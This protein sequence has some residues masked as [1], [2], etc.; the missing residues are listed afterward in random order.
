[1]TQPPPTAPGW[2]PDPSGT[3]SRYWDGNNWGPAAPPGADAPTPPRKKQPVP[4]WVIVFAVIAVLMAIGEIGSH[5]DSGH[6]ASQSS[7]NTGSQ[8]IG[9]GP[10]SEAG[11]PPST[12]PALAMVGQEVHD[13]KFAFVVNSVDRSKTAGDPSNEIE[14]VTAQGEFLNVHMTVTNVGDRTQNFFA[15]NQKLFIGGN[16]FSPNGTAAMWIGSMTVDINPGNN[17]QAVVSFDV[18]ANNTD[19]G[20]L[21]LHDSAFSGGVKVSL[22]SAGHPAGR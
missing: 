15:S 17:I 11:S 16:E 20:V 2:Y 4:K 5:S 1:M 18:P 10:R 7:S 14:T 21:A 9:A 6:S 8:R 22:Q 13:G 3:G 19:N 12:P